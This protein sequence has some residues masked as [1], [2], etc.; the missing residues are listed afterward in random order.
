MT[1]PN[2][3]ASMKFTTQG[4]HSFLKSR[5]RNSWDRIPHV[6]QQLLQRAFSI[7]M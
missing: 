7:P 3:L 2:Q 1:L 6:A 4:A 5:A